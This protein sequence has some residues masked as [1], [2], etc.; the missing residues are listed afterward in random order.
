MFGEREYIRE[1]LSSQSILNRISPLDIYLKYVGEFEP[2]KPC[3]SPLR[4]DDNPSF[5]IGEH[6]GKW[7]FKDFGTGEG[8]DCFTLVMKKF[9][10]TYME[11]LIIINND[12]KLGLEYFIY[13]ESI[14]KYIVESQA[15]ETKPVKYSTDKI[16]QNKKEILIQVKSRE[17]TNKDIEFWVGKYGISVDTLKHYNVKSL[18]AY[19]INDMQFNIGKDELCYG[20]RFKPYTYKIYRP[21][22]DKRYKW[23]TNS[24]HNV[25]QGIMQLK[26]KS[27]Y[28]VITKSLKDVMVLYENN[29]EAIAP[30]AES[31][32]ISEPIMSKLK[33]RYKKIYTLMDYDYTGIKL[34]NE[35]KKRYG[36]IPIAFT[37]HIWQRSQGY[38]G[39]KDIS[40]FTKMHGSEATRQL[41]TRF[42]G[43]I[44]P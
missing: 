31:V 8:G 28:L 21:N 24:K 20:Y 36:T 23:F 3:S 42:K 44:V 17:F 7:Y 32:I 9:G 2:N 19:W 5:V 16:K 12:F 25:V 18:D 14:A 43:R 11:S 4:K 27:D 33:E 26:F 22:R 29:I 1:R 30:Q 15:S 13:N 40:D 39:C 6:N 41:I 35:M 38:E 37:D 34:T 10:C